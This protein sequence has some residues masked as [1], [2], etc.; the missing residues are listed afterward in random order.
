MTPSAR[1]LLAADPFAARLGV[2][3]VEE[4]PHSLVV[5]MTV[6]PEHLDAT[7]RVPDGLVFSLADCAMSLMSNAAGRAVA[8]TTHLARTGECAP[9]DNLR[10]RVVLGAKDDIRAT[11]K[12]EVTT[13]RE[14]V[15]GTFTGTTLTL[16]SRP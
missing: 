10:A 12:V 2:A 14:T 11:W 15:V 9:G 6:R 4:A 3:V 13:G 7:G 5:E 8:I 1:D 16:R